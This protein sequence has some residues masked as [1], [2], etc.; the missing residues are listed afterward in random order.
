MKDKI[1]VKD[2]SHLKNLIR[3]EI[4]LNGNNCDLNHLDVSQITDMNGLFSNFPYGF[5][6]FNG[7][8]SNWDVS[9][10]E[11]MEET[12]NDSKFNGDISN[13][14]VSNVKSMRTMFHKSKFNGDISD[15]K[16]YNLEHI[17]YMFDSCKAIKPGWA[18]FF[19]K[20]EINK[21]LLERDLH[22]ELTNKNN[23]D[24]RI[25]I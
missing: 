2:I 24:K 23:N 10:V 11:K 19:S 1:I 17:V 15:W 9:K 20:Q 3:Q 7:D 25:K 18:K 4:K 16:P 21:Y 5:A 14:N 6:E 22:L 12:F 8:I 13:W